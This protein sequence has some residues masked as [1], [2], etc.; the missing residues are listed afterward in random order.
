VG[1]KN[2]DVDLKNAPPCIYGNNTHTHALKPQNR[3]ELA[4]QRSSSK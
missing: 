3:E 2:Y 1:L 4:L